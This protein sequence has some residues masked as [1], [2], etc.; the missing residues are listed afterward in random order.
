MTCEETQQAFSL[1]V[2]D[3]LAL[4]ARSA[5]DEH[6]RQCPVCRAHFVEMRSIIRGLGSLSRPVP[7]AGLAA[8]ISDT[9]LT[10]SSSGTLG[11]ANPYCRVTGLGESSAA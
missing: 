5:A 11:L 1:Y 2:D 8:S 3:Q 9:F 6:L 7:P 10:A 4:P